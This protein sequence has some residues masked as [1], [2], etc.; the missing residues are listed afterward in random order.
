MLKSRNCCWGRLFSLRIWIF[1]VS[2][3]IIPHFLQHLVLER[4]PPAKGGCAALWEYLW[5]WSAGRQ[6][7]CV[8]A[9]KMQ[10]QAWRGSFVCLTCPSTHR[11]A[12]AAVPGVHSLLSLLRGAGRDW[13]FQVICYPH[14]PNTAELVKPGRERWVL[15]G[16]SVSLELAAQA[17]KRAVFS[18]VQL[19]TRLMRGNQPL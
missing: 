8:S 10:M 11:H 18:G 13:L 1:P 6:A 15:W 17:V 9:G 12:T 16:F 7:R 5:E 19:R 3:K 14:V 4:I 2:S